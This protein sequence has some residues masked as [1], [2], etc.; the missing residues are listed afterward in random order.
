[1]QERR[2]ADGG[3]ARP[4][5]PGPARRSR[6][7][8]RDQVI[9][10]VTGLVAL[11]L[12]LSVAVAAYTVRGIVERQFEIRALTVARAAALDTRLAPW[13]DGPAT[14]DGPVQAAAERVR[15]GTNVQ[16]VVVL[17]ANGVRYSHPDASRVGSPVRVDLDPVL[18][19][20]ETMS[21]EDDAEGPAARARVP[22][23]DAAGRVVGVVS[24]GLGMGRVEDSVW[25]LTRGLV[26]A[27]VVVLVL[28][29]LGAF[30][31]A[32]RLRRTTHGLEP[33][34]MA[35]LLRGQ[36]ALLE[37][38]KDGVVAL[39]P[40]GVV[41]AAN[42]EAHRLMGTR[43]GVSPESARA[44]LPDEV[45]AL[46]ARPEPPR[47]ELTVVGDH[48][49]VATRLAVVRD[50]RDLGTVLVLRDESDLDDLARELEAT[51]AL[52]D[53]LRAQ[54]HEYTNRIHTVAGLLRLGHVP[55]A[56]EYLVQLQAS[57][58]WG[59]LV[60]DPYLAGLL[61][62]KAAVASEAGVVLR[63][64]DTTWVDRPLRHPLDCVT[65]VGNL[66][67][68]AV[69]AAQ[70]AATPD[71]DEPWV[72]VTLLADAA[73][74]VVHV[75]DSGPGVATEDREAIFRPGF[76]TRP[77]GSVDRRDHG[78]GLALA[79]RTARRHG[80]DVELVDPGS[81]DHGAAFSARLEHVVEPAT[82]AGRT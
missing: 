42:E 37:G 63:V 3:R 79:R 31:L 39:D 10:L 64:G 54:A 24:V 27:A 36:Q 71:G 25:A 13:L 34:E 11:T 65:V 18:A 78:L 41:T 58:A 30:V 19:G 77:G 55:Q 51:R 76:T 17:D 46:L 52:G 20:A 12:L 57:T 81:A 74:L 67:D 44:G 53:A 1:M 69:R 40:D 49:V 56:R 75:V 68:N 21:V 6:L 70:S 80:G 22:L 2:S 9:L 4:A 73:D 62:A 26:A 5:G 82:V 33:A 7:R 59:E 35:D 14:R 72:E 15:V 66:I 16:A 45:Q 50:G 43:P 48:T 47:G 28:G 8:L 29:V 38:V 32:R 61:T 23:R 60:D